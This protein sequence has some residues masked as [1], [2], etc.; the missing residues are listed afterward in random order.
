ME[1]ILQENVPNLG[2]VGDVVKVKN[3]YARNYLIP[4]QL[5]MPA[6]HGNIK[7]FEHMKKV[8]EVKKAEKQKEAQELQK[9]L[10]AV[11]LKTEQAAKDGKLFGSVTV[12]DLVS[13][14]KEAGF[15]IDRHL[16]KLAAPIK[17]VGDHSFDVKLHQDVVAS[18]KV[19]VEA[20]EA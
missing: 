3:G 10:E 14:L 12:T 20:K 18:I 13:L 16:V 7:A 19:T 11:S 2:F 1:V 5:A 17:A 9:R 4:K 6:S 8:I 15:E